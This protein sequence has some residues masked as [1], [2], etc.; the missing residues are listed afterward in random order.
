MADGKA[1]S[2]VLDGIRRHLGAGGD[3]AE[4]RRAAVEERLRRHARNLVPQRGQGSDADRL[5]LFRTMLERADATVSEVA[6]PDEVPEAVAGFLRERN[7]PLHLRMGEDAALAALPWDRTPTLEI[8]HVASLERP[9]PLRVL[10]DRVRQPEEQQTAVAGG[11]RAP[12]LACERVVRGTNGGVDV[13]GRGLGNE[14]PGTA[15]RRVDGLEPAAVTGRP[16]LAADEH[17]ELLK[18]CSL[19]HASSNKRAKSLTYCRLVPRARA[20]NRPARLDLWPAGFRDLPLT[21]PRCEVYKSK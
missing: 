21:G 13:V 6:S 10:C 20:V 4:A 14:G 17:P 8:V 19:S 1:R 11:E 5:A 16:R 9:D 18:S 15:G 3:N 2:S 12:G 7:L